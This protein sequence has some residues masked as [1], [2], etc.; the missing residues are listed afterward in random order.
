MGEE[1]SQ[2]VD[3]PRK[4]NDRGGEEQEAPNDVAEGKAVIPPPDQKIASPVKEKVAESTAEKISGGLDNRDDVLAKIANEKRLALIKAWE[5]SEKTKAENKA[6]KNQSAI[7]SW[8]STNKAS[9][10]A[11]LK[12]IEE[13][14]DKKKA[15]YVEKKKNKVAEVHRAAE[16]KRAAVEATRRGEFIKVEETAAKFRATGYVP[17]KLLSCFSY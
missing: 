8:E 3:A 9:V 7:G 16:E 13:K 1:G 5:E 17:K 12:K 11:Q 10:E 4:E 2:K 6:Y 14:F 15:K